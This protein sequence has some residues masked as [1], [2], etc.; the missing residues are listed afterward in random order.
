MGREEQGRIQCMDAAQV[1]TLRKK[2]EAALKTSSSTCSTIQSSSSTRP[3]KF[4]SIELGSQM[5]SYPLG[6]EMG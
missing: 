2:E 4:N 3:A 5:S 1:D 6:F